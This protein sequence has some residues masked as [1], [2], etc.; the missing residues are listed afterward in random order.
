VGWHGGQA[1]MLYAVASTGALSLGSIMPH[2]CETEHEW[3]H[4]LA[5]RLYIEVRSTAREAVTHPDPEA[6]ADADALAE[7]AD[8]LEVWQAAHEECALCGAEWPDGITVGDDRG[9][10]E[11]IC[12]TCLP[13]L[14]V[15]DEVPVLPPRADR[16]PRQ[17]Y[18]WPYPIPL[19][20]EGDA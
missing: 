4:D 5:E 11:P 19:T 6:R 17:V 18:R 14:E 1:S 12:A 15:P 10:A 8:D 16:V 7:W 13:D 20:T 3:R 9:V 2:K